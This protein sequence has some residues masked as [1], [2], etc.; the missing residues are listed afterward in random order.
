MDK[1]AIQRRS[2]YPILLGVAAS[3][4]Y[5]NSLTAPFVLD[6]IRFI[7]HSDWIDQIWPLHAEV[8]GTRRPLLFLS[9]ILNHAIGGKGVLGYHLFNILVHIATAITFFALGRRLLLR[10]D[11]DKQR[12]ELVAFGVSLV[13]TVHP[14]LTQSVTYIVQRGESM[15][16]L[17]MLIGLLAFAQGSGDAKRWK[18]WWMV[19]VAFAAGIFSKETAGIFPI[20]LV[21]FDWTFHSKSCR[22]MWAH[23]KWVY[24]S[25]LPIALFFAVR[26][27]DQGPHPTTGFSLKTITPLEYSLSQPLIIL[28]YLSLSFYPDVL[29]LDYWWEPNLTWFCVAPPVILLTAFFAACVVG[30]AWRHPAG[31]VGMSFFVLLAP[32]S[33]IIPIKD[34]A[35]EHRMYL[36]L[37]C[38]IALFM[39]GAEYVI[40]QVAARRGCG[41]YS[42]MI[43]QVLLL[44]IALPLSYRTVLRNSDYRSVISIWK[45]T[46]E[47]RPFNPRAHSNYAIAL[48]RQGRTEEALEHLYLAQ[49]NTQIVGSE[50]QSR[51]CALGS[52]L[53]EIARY[54]KAAF[55]LQRAIDL[56]NDSARGHNNLGAIY[57]H[58]GKSDLAEHHFREAIRLRKKDPLPRANLAR[59]LVDSGQLDEADVELQQA[60]Q[61]NPEL[62]LSQRTLVHLRFARGEVDLAME[63]LDGLIAKHPKA[64]GLKHDFAMALATDD[65]P[66]Q[67]DIKR[68]IEIAV[69]LQIQLQDSFDAPRASNLLAVARAANG[70]FAAAIEASDQAIAAARTNE[71]F[72]LAREFEEDRELFAS[73]K[74]VH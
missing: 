10:L 34:L 57:Q 60:L 55:Y 42:V 12:S 13:W 41:G 49:W 71:Q 68:S 8:L 5:F 14:L 62:L 61:L 9:L 45:Q 1:T 50:L 51:Y 72:H 27:I 43:Y 19:P 53:G 73:G 59:V 7:F 3:I 4:V 67:A 18:R 74:R 44:V 35:V 47:T 2:T 26:L 39:V 24:A 29:C 33:S 6:D 21:L 70:E 32:S 56:H 46:I 28:H 38:V 20:L 30:L 64:Y 25:L 65:N 48:H 16:A 66:T 36:P 22:E 54:E 63:L 31:F 37:A 69:Q 23:H 40:S 52:T 11:Y 15:A 17:A 58:L